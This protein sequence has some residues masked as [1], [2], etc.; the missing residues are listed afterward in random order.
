MDW[1]AELQHYIQIDTSQPNVNY[2]DAILYLTDLTKRI[3]KSLTFRIYM[4]NNVPLLVVTKH[5]RT[6]KSILLNSHMDVVNVPDANQWTFPPFSGHYDPYSDKI[7]GR[8]TQ[9]MKA[10]GIQYMAAMYNLR[11]VQLQYTV[12]V[13]F[14]PNRELGGL[15]G[16]ANFVKTQ[17]FRALEVLFVVD[18][19]CASPFNHFLLF[20]TERTAWQFAIKIKAQTGHAAM[21]IADTCENKLRRLLI[22]VDKFRMH[23]AQMNIAKRRE[24]KI[25]YS[26]TVN[27]TKIESA[28]TGNVLLPNELTVFFDMRIGVETSLNYILDE[29]HR[30]T[31]VASPNNDVTIEWIYRSPKSLET[32]LQ[33]DMCMKFIQF[34]QDHKIPYALTIAPCSSDAKYLRE[35]GVPVLGFTPI[36]MTPPLWHSTNEYIYK[37]Q[38]IKNTNLMTMLINFIAN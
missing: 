37:K 13:M 22:E 10:Q 21:P 35:E 34:F 7:Y 29:I 25:G 28:G 8:G 15:S 12:H 4:Q 24:Q 18:E 2:S 30:W 36:N 14:V 11:D 27:M 3:G 31:L 16:M 26:T 23:D 33:H 5:G 9:D 19:S 6:R 38:Y 32:N 1:T 17:D 20:F